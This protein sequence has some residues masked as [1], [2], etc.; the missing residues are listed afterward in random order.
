MFK[1]LFLFSFFLGFL[2]FISLPLKRFQSL[3]SIQKA[4][5]TITWELLSKINYQKKPHKDYPDGVSFPTV[6]ATLKKLKG[7]KVV[8]TGYIIPADSLNYILNKYNS[9]SISCSRCSVNIISENT[10]SLKFKSKTLKLKSDTC[11]TIKGK[12]RYNETDVD[13]WIYH[14]DDAVIVKAR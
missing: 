14:L 7:K 13:D 6:N 3:D 2:S 8:I 11:V 10:I 12:F 4:S 9:I 1:K 5:D